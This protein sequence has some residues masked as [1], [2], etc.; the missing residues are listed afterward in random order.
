[1]KAILPIFLVFLNVTLLAQNIPSIEQVEGEL[2]EL[3]KKDD[4]RTYALNV[5]KT[6]EDLLQ[7]M[8]ENIDNSQEDITELN[9][10][11]RRAHAKFTS[12]LDSATWVN[13]QLN[14]ELQDLSDSLE[15]L[16][17]WITSLEEF[18]ANEIKEK[19]HVR[20]ETD[21]G[22]KSKVYYLLKGY[23]SPEE[24][25]YNRASI[26]F[27]IL[28]DNEDIQIQPI[29]SP[30][31]VNP[32]E[33]IQVPHHGLGIGPHC[34]TT[35]EYR[36]E[37]YNMY[38]R[39]ETNNED[40]ETFC[41]SYPDMYRDAHLVYD[42]YK[43]SIISLTTY[44]MLDVSPY[45]YQYENFF[46]IKNDK[47][48]PVGIFL[49]SAMIPTKL[50]A[51]DASCFLPEYNNSYRGDYRDEDLLQLLETSIHFES[52]M[53]NGMPDITYTKTSYLSDFYETLVCPENTKTVVEETYIFN[54][55]EY[56]LAGQ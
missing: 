52:T 34:D 15:H 3:K 25:E 10:E 6:Y 22:G 24:L 38:L 11:L 45:Y 36:N 54:G 7:A 2:E 47:L 29:D 4:L 16:Q 26:I 19:S 31:C 27:C 43:K 5:I 13:S 18:H 9:N 40:C 44:W 1:M 39:D 30:K 33:F 37:A 23:T 12:S 14:S 49:E 35:L 32:L 28:E 21:G 20:I 8:Q 53:H 46:M 56:E 51:S 48:V 17:Q 55:V 42:N 50:H 41:E